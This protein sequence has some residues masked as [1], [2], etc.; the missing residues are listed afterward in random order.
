MGGENS[1]H[2]RN[3]DPHPGPDARATAPSSARSPVELLGVV[4]GLVVSIKPSMRHLSLSGSSGTST[5]GYPET[6][7][8]QSSG[9]QFTLRFDVGRV[10]GGFQR[11][12]SVASRGAVQST[13]H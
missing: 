13:Q 5:N 9:L 4:L 3:S 1:H 2:R 10:L 6:S 8:R 12:R 7:D 11:A